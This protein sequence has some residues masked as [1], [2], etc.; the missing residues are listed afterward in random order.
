[1]SWFAAH[2]VLYVKL[3]EHPQKRFPLW[4]N[5]VLIKADSE[6]EALAKAEQ[7]GREEEG[8]DDGSFRWGGRPAT[9][10][11]AGVRKITSCQDPEKRPNDGTEISYI[12]MELASQEL[13]EQ[14]A[15]GQPVSVRFKEKYRTANRD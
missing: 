8:D 5:I 3:K 2:L 10:V 11:F 1:M 6:D 4:E 9:W 15:Q 12:E 13:V 14:F 7:H